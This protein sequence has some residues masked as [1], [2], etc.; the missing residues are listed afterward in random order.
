MNDNINVVV[1]NNEIFFLKNKE[2]N[3]IMPRLRKGK[4]KVWNERQEV[5]KHTK[6]C[7]LIRKYGKKIF[8]VDLILRDD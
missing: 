4:I 2:F 6:K 8:D 3:W 1:L 5:I 7:A